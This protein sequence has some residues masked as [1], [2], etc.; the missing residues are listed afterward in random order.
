MR[1]LR[2]SSKKSKRDTTGYIYTN[3]R[4][5]VL[6]A[7]L[8]NKDDFQKFLKMSQ[9]EIARY[10]Q[11][12][13]YKK[14]INDLSVRFSGANLI[15]YALNKN[16][17]NTLA[18]ILGFALRGAKDQIRL[19]LRRYDVGNI[20]TI[21]RGKFSKASDEKIKN[22]LIAGGE[23]SQIFLEDAVKKSNTIENAIEHFKGTDY[24]QTMKKFSK[25]L[26]KL[27]DE[28]DKLYYKI[29]LDHAEKE[30]EDYIRTEILVKNTLNRLRAK[31]ANIKV[32]IILGE[33]KMKVPYGEDSVGARVYMKKLLIEKAVKMVHEVRRN[34]R[35]VLGYIIAKEN[36]VNNIR[37]LNRGRHSGLKEDLIQAQLVI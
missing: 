23:F 33:R 7:K 20:K 30:L 9:A 35:P 1:L 26:T 19:Y 12:T 18:R 29:V 17:E 14:E 5:K 8:F 25:D 13:E 31:K 11:E 32:E 34:V 3:T 36:E 4:V 24:Y 21:L 10:L 6:K 15:E 2:K 22:E 28:L 37:I 27:E 16:L